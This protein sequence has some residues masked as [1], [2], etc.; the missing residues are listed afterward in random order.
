M[1]KL[2]S[3]LACGILCFVVTGCSGSKDPDVVCTKDSSNSKEKFSLYVDGDTIVDATMEVEYEASSEAE[4]KMAASMYEGIFGTL[5][6]ESAGT[7]E[8]DIERDGNTVKVELNIDVE[9]ANKLDTATAGV[10]TSTSLK[11][12]IET[13]EAQGYN[14]N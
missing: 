13:V 4:A 14:C 2:L 7:I 12:Y 11:E 9:A 8:A 10:P 6:D 5:E 1:K 3:L